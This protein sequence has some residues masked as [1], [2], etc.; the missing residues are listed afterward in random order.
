MCYAIIEMKGVEKLTI[1]ERVRKI[2]KSL[3]M[4]Q[5]DFGKKIAVKQGYL[6]NIENGLRDVSEKIIKLICS[7][8]HVRE[9]WIR[10]GTGTMFEESD[11]SIL[12]RLKD[13][14]GADELDLQIVS[15]YL[16]LQPE[17]RRV[18]KEYVLT[19]ASSYLQASAAQAPEPAEPKTN[20]AIEKELEDYRRELEAEELA[21]RSEASRGQGGDIA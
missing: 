15:K 12:N 14:Y 17:K 7:E 16:Q 3:D 13:E 8:Y 6:T 10:N 19:V 1:N 4:N 11:N 9:E 20:P 2:R 21:K 5:T 18:I